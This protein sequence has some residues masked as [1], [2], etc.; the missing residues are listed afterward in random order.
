MNYSLVILSIVFLFALSSN[1]FIESSDEMEKYLNCITPLIDQLAM[2]Y[3]FEDTWNYYR[4]SY[5]DIRDRFY[6]C[7]ELKNNSFILKYVIQF[8]L[9]LFLLQILSIQ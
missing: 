5:L 2:E 6:L 8:I 4:Q 1:A 3:D 7:L 9:K